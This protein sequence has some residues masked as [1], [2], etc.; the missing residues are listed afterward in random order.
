MPQGLQLPG[1]DYPVVE[2]LPAVYGKRKINR[3]FEGLA[4]SPDEKTLFVV[5]QSPLLNPD[6]ATGNP[7]RMSR[8]L[9]FDVATEKPTAEYVYRFDAVGDFDLTANRSATEMK[10]SAV[11]ALSADSLLI[12]ERTDWVAKIYRADLSQAT[13][14]LGTR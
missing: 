10:L 13:N 11:V 2:A 14:I 12:L 3:G 7:S 9:A 8:I 6:T 4:V 1:A 5:L